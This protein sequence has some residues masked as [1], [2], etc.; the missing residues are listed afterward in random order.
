MGLLAKVKRN[1]VFIFHLGLAIVTSQINLLLV[2]CLLTACIKCKGNF[3][4]VL[5]PLNYEYRFVVRCLFEGY[6]VIGVNDLVVWL[7]LV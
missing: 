4:L 3:L 2:F 1:D 5:L 6:V 7:E